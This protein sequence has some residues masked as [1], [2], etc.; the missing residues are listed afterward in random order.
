VGRGG[1]GGEEKMEG[2][3]SDPHSVEN[4]KKGMQSIVFL[5][6]LKLLDCTS[7]N[8]YGELRFNIFYLELC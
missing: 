3:K 2:I 4:I 8:T 7:N 6:F 1:G 5:V